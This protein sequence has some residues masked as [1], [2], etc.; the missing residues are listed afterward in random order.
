[1]DSM[2]NVDYGTPI[3]E[4]TEFSVKIMH[5]KYFCFM[6][7][8]ILFY[9]GCS[10]MDSG[11]SKVET[12]YSVQ[13][14]RNWNYK[15]YLPSDYS[16]NVKISY[17]VIYLLHGSNGDEHDWDFIYPLLDSLIHGNHIPPLIT[18]A[19]ATGTSW[20]INSDSNK[21]E[22]AFNQDLILQI[23]HT[24]RTYSNRRS[25]GIIGYSMGGYGVLRYML[26]YS[27]IY[28]AAMILSPA[29]YEDLPPKGS[30]AIE[31]GVFR[32]PFDKKLW[33]ALNYTV[34]LNNYLA[35][36]LFVPLFIA[37]GDDDWN[38]KDDFKYNIEYQ[39]LILYEKLH[40]E[41]GS[42]AELRIVNGGH[43]K[44]VW[45]K[46]FVEGIQYMFKYINVTG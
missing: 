29:L 13:L 12:F 7:F 21:Y 17:P 5:L 33:K 26:V 44:E 40:K 8:I 20:W 39:S 42:P 28:G 46:L 25:R 43:T 36:R 32:K 45:E 27:E 16:K 41:G 19:P 22:T 30:S 10:Q 9:A 37:S 15:I 1:M 18:V 11:I 6:L 2:I 4:I 34:H 24:Y 23:D 38:H 35:K 3:R 31:S 14:G